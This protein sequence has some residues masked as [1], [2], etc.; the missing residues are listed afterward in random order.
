MQAR[1]LGVEVT[2]RQF[3]ISAAEI[4][5]ATRRVRGLIGRC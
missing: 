1:E 2:A 3:G 5:A 4:R